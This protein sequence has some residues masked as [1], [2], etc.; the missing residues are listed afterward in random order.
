MTVCVNVSGPL[1]SG[2]VRSQFPRSRVVGSLGEIVAHLLPNAIREVRAVSGTDVHIAE[3]RGE[4]DVQQAMDLVPGV[5][6]D[7]LFIV[8]SSKEPSMLFVGEYSDRYYLIVPVKLLPGESW[9]ES[10]FIDGKQRFMRR[11]R[12]QENLLYVKRG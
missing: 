9:L 11:R 4:F 5:L 3:H 12:V 10:L 1:A 8:R 2:T 7:P 6:A